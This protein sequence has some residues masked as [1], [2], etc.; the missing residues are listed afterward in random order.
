MIKICVYWVLMRKEEKRDIY[1]EQKYR[2]WVY[3]DKFILIYIQR[4]VCFCSLFILCV[5]ILKL[6]NLFWII[7][8]KW[9]YNK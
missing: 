8:I 2:I 3:K 6:D 7:Y 9:L 1:Y 5:D 4:F